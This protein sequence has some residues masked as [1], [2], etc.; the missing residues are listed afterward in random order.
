MY[1]RLPLFILVLLG[2][3]AGSGGDII[4][5]TDN[6]IAAGNAVIVFSVELT[7]DTRFQ[8]C[9]V[10]GGT[11]ASTAKWFGWNAG[12]SRK[13]LFAIE[14]PAEDYEFYRFGCVYNGLA[15]STS[16]GPRLGLNAGDVK[17][18][19]RLEVYD[20]QFGSA[21]GHSR[22]PTAVRFR[23]EDESA[24]DLADLRAR[25]PFL[26]GQDVSI[27]VLPSWGGPGAKTL[28]PYRAGLRIV[29]APVA[30]AFQN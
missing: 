18:L 8:Q 29:T 28:R 9:S 10:F 1:K 22:M 11:A 13:T 5:A 3:C 12:E 19:G 25:I 6:S 21:A 7:D 16:D 27:D 4:Q 26:A 23:V 30:G 15:V 14:V 24:S 2:A 20:T 17:Y